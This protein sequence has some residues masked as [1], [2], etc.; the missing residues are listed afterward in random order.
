VL[1]GLAYL[2]FVSLGLPDGLIGVAW[3]SIRAH[4]NLPVDALG[5]LLVMFTRRLSRVEL[6]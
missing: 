1:I 5:W 3:P 2:A 6:Y 4:F